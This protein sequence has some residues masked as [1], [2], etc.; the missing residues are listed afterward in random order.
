[1]K[2]VP[3]V[4]DKLLDSSSV[5]A[6][7]INHFILPTDQARTPAAQAKKLRINPEAVVD[8]QIAEVGVAGAAQP[9]LLLAKALENAKPGEH[10][11]LIG[12]G[13]GCDA[14]LLKATD[15]ITSYKPSVGVSAALASRHEE[16][17]Y[18]KFLSFNN[19]VERDIG[20]RAEVDLSLIHI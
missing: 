3:T 5:S 19:L 6:E 4:V 14:V 15:A 10:I 13:Q 1:M 12:F 2:S 16:L 18:N 9:I 8:N 20:K 17:N 11:L 7:Q